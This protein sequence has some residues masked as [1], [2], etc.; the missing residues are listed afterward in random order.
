MQIKEKVQVF[1]V[2]LTLMHNK[3]RMDALCIRTEET[4]VIAYDIVYC[5][6]QCSVLALTFCV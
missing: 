2:S 6:F 4:V 5:I 1:T 3:L